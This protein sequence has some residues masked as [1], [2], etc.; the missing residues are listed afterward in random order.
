MRIMQELFYL[1]YNVPCKSESIYPRKYSGINCN[2]YSM[3]SCIP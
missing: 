3:V 1:K 2:E